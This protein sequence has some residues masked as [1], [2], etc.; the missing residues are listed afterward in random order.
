MQMGCGTLDVQL[1]YQVT[2]AVSL[3]HIG[4]EVV[5]TLPKQS[6]NVPV[7]SD[8]AVGDFL[9]GLVDCGIPQVHFF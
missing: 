1:A 8:F 6:G 9:H 3:L 5:L 2:L 7:A 4:L